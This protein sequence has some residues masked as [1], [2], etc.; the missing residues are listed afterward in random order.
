[1]LNMMVLMLT[2]QHCEN[3]NE[4]KDYDFMNH[5][6]IQKRFTF[7]LF[8]STDNGLKNF[9]EKRFVIYFA[10]FFFLDYFK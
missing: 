6:I 4:L 5:F 3:S 9:M 7:S 10:I 8:Q 2:P 1:M